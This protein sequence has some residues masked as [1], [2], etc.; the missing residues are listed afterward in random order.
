MQ[1]L[2]R[3]SS[4]GHA[5]VTTVSIPPRAPRRWLRV[6]LAVLAIVA[7]LVTGVLV[8]RARASASVSYVTQPVVQLAG[9]PVCQRL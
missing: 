1:T 8:Y 9:G 7:L 6:A 2:E 5:R 3:P 4:N